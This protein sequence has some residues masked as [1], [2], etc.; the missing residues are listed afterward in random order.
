MHEFPE[1]ENDVLH[2]IVHVQFSIAGASEKAKDYA[3]R[4]PTIQG[5]VNAKAADKNGGAKYIKNASKSFD[6]W[7]RPARDVCRPSIAAMRGSYVSS[8]SRLS[9]GAQCSRGD[10]RR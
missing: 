1:N 7:T 10:Q 9:Q 2:K 3:A 8:T 4:A 6:L 5:L